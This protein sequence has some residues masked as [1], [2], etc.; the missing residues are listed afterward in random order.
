MFDRRRAIC[1]TAGLPLACA[2]LA[3]LAWCG[4][5]GAQTTLPA[6][7]PAPG[8]RVILAP[9]TAAAPAARAQPMLTQGIDE[10]SGQIRL[11]AG[12]SVALST[13]RPYRRIS[14]GNPDIADV[15]AISPDELLLTGKK[16]G[17]TQLMV[18]D[19]EGRSQL[20]Q[21]VVEYD[22]RGLNEQLKRVFPGTRIE[23]SEV[24]GAILLRGQMQSLTEVDRA[25]K[26][27]EP[28]GKVLNFVE[29]AGVRQILL[30][31]RFAEVMRSVSSQFG[32]NLLYVDTSGPTPFFVGNNVGQISP[33]SIVEGVEPGTIAPGVPSPSS[34]TT[35]FGQASWNNGERAFV[36]FLS[37]L[38]QNNLLRIL[39]EPN[40]VATSGESA[41]FHAGGEFP[42]PVPQSGEDDV[43]TVDYKE[44]G[45]K[46]QFLAQVLGNGRIRMTVSPEVSELDFATPLRLAGV[47]IPAINTRRVTTTVELHSGQSLAIGGLLNDQMSANKDAIP[48]LGDL[49][50]LGALFRSVRYQRRETEL[51]VFVTPMLM[52]PL[53]PDQVPLL[54]GEVWRHPTE[55]EMLLKGEIGRPVETPA[56]YGPYGFDR[57]ATDPGQ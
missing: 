2:G 48:L 21:V 25:V 38:R 57:A 41:S 52:A 51:V 50:V 37:A 23:A 20:V 31:V 54:P 26:L 8:P 33:F 27:A 6:T 5:A 49:P 1:V 9:A 36:G 53:N 12:E 39:A 56:F 17:V 30:Q 32:T 29:V 47:T 46:L 16:P 7:R 15:N 42:I 18:W 40:L 28:Y 14:V 45:V 13:E 35:L 55:A 10:E 24:N 44:F 43:I 22:V 3:L 4:A 11:T 34:V 19:D